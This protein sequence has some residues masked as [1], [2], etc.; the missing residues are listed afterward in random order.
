MSQT[1]SVIFNSTEFFSIPKQIKIKQGL[2]L[3]IELYSSFT[4][5]YPSDNTKFYISPETYDCIGVTFDNNEMYF[6]FIG[7]KTSDGQK[8][9]KFTAS[10]AE[11]DNID[12]IY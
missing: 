12:L 6:K 1:R 8:Y 9:Q 4:A 10:I 11:T 2:S 3:H 5:K 7:Y